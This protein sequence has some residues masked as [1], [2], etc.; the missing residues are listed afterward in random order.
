MEPET[1]PEIMETRSSLEGELT[2]RCEF[3]CDPDKS[4]NTGDKCT[5]FKEPLSCSKCGKIFT[6]KS[7]LNWHERIHT[8]GKQF[9]CSECGKK[10]SQAGGL[11]THVRVHT[12]EKPYSCSICNKKFTQASNL[13]THKRTHTGEKPFSCSKCDKKFNQ[14]AHLKTHERTHTGGDPFS[15]SQCNYNCSTSSVWKHGWTHTGDFLRIFCNSMWNV[16]EKHI[17]TAKQICRQHIASNNSNQ[18]TKDSGVKAS[19]RVAKL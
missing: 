12:N 6:S 19:G 4:G 5:T 3:S 1:S 13:K 7:A 9:S 18:S 2:I 8:S 15:C 14:A 17:Q 11:K 16:W 10:F